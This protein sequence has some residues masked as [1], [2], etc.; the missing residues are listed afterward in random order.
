MLTKNCFL[1]SLD[2]KDAYFYFLFGIL[3]GNI[4]DLSLT[5]QCTNITAYH[6]VYVVRRTF[7]LN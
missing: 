4:C 6:L 2:L 7:L 5:A 1:A 3:T